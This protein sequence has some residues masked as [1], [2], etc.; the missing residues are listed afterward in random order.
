ENAGL[1]G[2]I[3]DVARPRHAGVT[4]DHRIAVVDVDAAHGDALVHLGSRGA[5][6][7]QQDLVEA[8]ALDLVR[9]VRL[10]PLLVE[11]DPPLALSLGAPDEG[12]TPLDHESGALDLIA[13]AEG[14]Q[15]TEAPGNQRLADVVTRELLL[16]EHQH[17]VTVTRQER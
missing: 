13:Y 5:C 11:R 7:V 1:T 9:V 10:A 8:R 15:N 17:P 16:L 4:D 2:R 6:V 3:D 14:V 12:A